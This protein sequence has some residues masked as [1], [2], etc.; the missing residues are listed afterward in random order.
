MRWQSTLSPSERG[1]FW[2]SAIWGSDAEGKPLRRLDGATPSGRRL[3]PRAMQPKEAPPQQIALAA[4]G[5]PAGLT[6]G[7]PPTDHPRKPQDAK[8]TP[9]DARREAWGCNHRAV[10]LSMVGGMR[11][12][13]RPYFGGILDCSGKTAERSLARR[14]VCGVATGDAR[15]WRPEV[16]LRGRVTLSTR[17]GCMVFR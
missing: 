1:R 10:C 4:A 3:S 2:L 6:L 5:T 14:G 15:G 7:Y 17:L 11:A 8:R 12:W 16:T 13:Q 9:Q